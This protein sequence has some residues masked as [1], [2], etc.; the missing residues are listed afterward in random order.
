MIK[1]YF[2][3]F[4][5]ILAVVFIFAFK[6][7]NYSDIVKINIFCPAA[8]CEKIEADLVELCAGSVEVQK[9]EEIFFDM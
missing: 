2:I 8:S 7:E 3:I 5:S 4:V 6:V 1:K 9:Q